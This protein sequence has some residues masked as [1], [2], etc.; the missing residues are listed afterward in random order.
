MR[1]IRFNNRQQN[2]SFAFD[3]FMVLFAVLL[4]VWWW[5]CL[6]H[7]SSKVVL[8]FLMLIL[9]FRSSYWYS[10][11][12]WMIV[13]RCKLSENS[14]FNGFMPPGLQQQHSIIIHIYIFVTFWWIQRKEMS[15]RIKCKKSFV[16]CCWWWSSCCSWSNDEDIYVHLNCSSILTY[17][18]IS[19]HSHISSR[20]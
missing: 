16:C 12:I 18:G 15:K 9:P 1:T 10:S 2:V 13:I 20:T 7:G 4:Q 6:L 19:H 14:I 8:A 17:Y 3:N 5:W 11:V